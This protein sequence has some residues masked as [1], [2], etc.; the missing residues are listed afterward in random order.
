ME[1]KFFPPY[2]T[3]RIVKDQMIQPIFQKHMPL[4]SLFL[5]VV[6]VVRELLELLTIL[7][8]LIFIPGVFSALVDLED[9]KIYVVVLNPKLPRNHSVWFFNNDGICPG[10]SGLDSSMEDPERYLEVESIVCLTKL[11]RKGEAF[12][13]VVLVF[14]EIA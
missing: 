3:K 4:C 2:H 5:I 13:G 7:L 11:I 9:S 1:E 6:G 12:G 14:L 8:F 10:L